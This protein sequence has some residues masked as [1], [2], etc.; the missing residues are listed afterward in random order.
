MDCH[1]FKIECTMYKILAA[2][3]QNIL[4]VISKAI[5]PLQTSCKNKLTDVRTL[6]TLMDI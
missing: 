1:N 4:A 2:D 6:W 5:L 3:I